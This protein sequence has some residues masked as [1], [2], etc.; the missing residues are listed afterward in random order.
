MASEYDPAAGADDE[1]YTRNEVGGD[2]YVT[3]YKDLDRLRPEQRKGIEN[4]FRAIA[5]GE[6]MSTALRR[7]GERLRLDPIDRFKMLCMVYFEKFGGDK[8]YDVVTWN[9][10]MGQLPNLKWTAFRNPI[11]YVIGAR[12]IGRDKKISKEKLDL[13]YL[14]YSDTLSSESITKEDVIRYARHWEIL[15]R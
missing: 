1:G 11:G 6:N 2:P 4:I 10:L 7:A 5:D 14:S 9:D 13:V 8:H 15:L 3:S 12:I